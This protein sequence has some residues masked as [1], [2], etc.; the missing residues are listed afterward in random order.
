MISLLSSSVGKS[1]KNNSSKRPRLNSS[2]G[3]IDT[4]FAVATTNTCFLH[5]CSQNKN[6]PTILVETPPSPIA[7]DN[8]FSISSIH[9]IHGE[10]FSA[11]VNASLN[12][13]SDCP[14]YFP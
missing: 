6:C 11:V 10:T 5:S 7:P 12:C 2:D 4:S 3:N 13:C 1:T 14:T 8:P 9:K